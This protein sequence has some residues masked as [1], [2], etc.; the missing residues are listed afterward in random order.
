MGFTTEQGV[1]VGKKRVAHN[2]ANTTAGPVVTEK[3]KRPKL[4]MELGG[5]IPHLLRQRYLDKIIDELTPKCDSEKTAIEKVLATV[6]WSYE[7]SFVLILG[8][9]REK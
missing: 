1:Y 6:T 5:K 7:F 4:P 2:Y 8:Q 9:V 3:V